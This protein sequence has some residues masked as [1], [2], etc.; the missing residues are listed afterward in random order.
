MVGPISS[1]LPGEAPK[2][3]KGKTAPPKGAHKVGADAI[4]KGGKDPT[5]AIEQKITWKDKEIGKE[6]GTIWKRITGKEEVSS[7][8]KAFREETQIKARAARME[9]LEELAA[10]HDELAIDLLNECKNGKINADQAVIILGTI[11]QHNE[12]VEDIIGHALTPKQ[13]MASYGQLFTELKK[14]SKNPQTQS[15]IDAVIRK[16]AMK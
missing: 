8:Q 15:A 13:K 6:V 1:K 11:Q 10:T 16:H 7:E 12:K 9:R 2:P 14:L 4:S 3:E 5:K